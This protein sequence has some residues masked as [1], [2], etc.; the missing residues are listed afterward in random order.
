[1]SIAPTGLS[2]APRG[3]EVALWIGAGLLL[4]AGWAAFHFLCDDAYIAFRYVAARQAGWG[5]TWNPPPFPAVEGYS[6]FLWILI[7]DAV[8]TLTGASPPQSAPVLSLICTAATAWSVGRFAM[9]LPLP[10][11]YAPHRLALLALLLALPLTNRTV[12]AWASSGLETALWM[13]LLARWAVAA[14]DDRRA[15]LAGYAALMSLARPDG[16]LFFGATALWIALRALRDRRLPAS[17][18]A[19]LLVGAHLL[20]RKLTYGA[21]V[22]NPYFAK[23]GAGWPEAGLRHLAYFALEY[24]AFLW[25]LPIGLAALRVGRSLPAGLLLV[26]GAV[27]AH[28]AYYVLRVGG[29]HFEHRIFLPLIWLG[30]AGLVAALPRLF[31]LPRQGLLVGGL[32][33][34]L[35]WPIPWTHHLQTRDLSTRALTHALIEPMAPHLPALGPWVAAWDAHQAWLIPRMIALRHAEH[36]VLG[37]L[38]ARRYPDP[39]RIAQGGLA[40][41]GVVVAA[42]SVDGAAHIELQRDP[43]PLWQDWPVIDLGTAGAAWFLFPLPVI[44]R[45]GLN[46]PLIAHAGYRTPERI[47]AHEVVPPAGYIDCFAPNAYIALILRRSD[48]GA[49]V[50]VVTPDPGWSR[51][52]DVNSPGLPLPAEF[53]DSGLVGELGLLLVERP[54]PFGAAGVSD[55]LARSYDQGPEP[56]SAQLSVSAVQAFAAES[57]RAR[58]RLRSSP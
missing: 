53:A 30:W 4:L 57:A 1:V 33:L 2:A 24:A 8:Q 50:R 51:S 38:Q 17:L 56:A 47:H 27:G 11:S 43:A 7:L 34:A 3:V 54:Q 15:A 36:A 19:G 45:Y 32:A 28:Q 9:R 58:A 40:Q 39:A 49:A 14:L 31:A 41:G 10:A 21:W 29:D 16:L 5:Y 20:W 37:A 22:P 23:V 13:L 48:T 52:I 25:P 42:R 55:C 6:S 46:D 18:L 44:D 26:V 12:F 35:S